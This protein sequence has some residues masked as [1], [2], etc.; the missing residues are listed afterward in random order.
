MYKKDSVPCCSECGLEEEPVVK[1][2][3]CGVDIKKRSLT[4]HQKSKAHRQAAGEEEEPTAV[5]AEK[6]CG[7]CK[8]KP[9]SK[10][11]LK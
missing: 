3:P 5:D 9:K 4:L 7:T 10:K 1:C 2:E 11:V 6:R 8:R